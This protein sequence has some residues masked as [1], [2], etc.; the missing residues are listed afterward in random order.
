VKRV[1][2]DTN[3]VV[4]ACLWRGP[5]S[6]CLEA[7]SRGAFLALVSPPILAEY[8][9]VL[10]RLRQRYP[11]KPWVDW[12]SALRDAAELVFPALQIPDA[13]VD[14]DDAIFAECAVAGEADCLVSGDKA[15]LQAAASVRGIPILSPARFLE[16]LGAET[17]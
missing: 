10:E 16:I 7:W 12:V 11:D 5:S 3:V 6:Q 15:H 1:V 4:S 14:P 9:D 8:V 13:F 17:N 2:L